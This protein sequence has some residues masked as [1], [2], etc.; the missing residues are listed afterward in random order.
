MEFERMLR[1]CAALELNNDRTWFHENHRWYEEAK[2]DFIELTE[3][4]KFKVAEKTSPVLA[5]RL[6][7]A[8]AKDLLYRIPRDMRIRRNAPPY[9]PSWRAYLAADRHSIW[10]VGYYYMIA[11]GNRS[12]F[13]TGAWCEDQDWLRH[14]RGYISDHFDRFFE[15]YTE[16][17]YPLLEEE[18]NKL[19][20]VPRGFE[21]GDPAAE[22]LKYKG[23]YVAVSFPD[24]TLTDFDG[25]VERCGEAVERME[26]LRQFFDDAFARKPRDPWN[27][28]DWQ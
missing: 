18:G 3:Q 2:A 24:E 8:K 12:H 21:P 9:N 4:L 7:Y 27:P 15:A 20:K 5:E 25:F 19:K 28:G 14:I 6:L 17:G 1:Y 11:P 26:P 10:P 16:A 22:F 13:G 23:W